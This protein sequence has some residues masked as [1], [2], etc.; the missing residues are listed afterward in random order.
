MGDL[1]LFVAQ[2][3]ALGLKTHYLVD[4]PLYSVMRLFVP[5]ELVGS[6]GQLVCIEH[7]KTVRVGLELGQGLEEAWNGTTRRVLNL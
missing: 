3:T 6:T 1:L 7:L 4:G 2:E 5:H